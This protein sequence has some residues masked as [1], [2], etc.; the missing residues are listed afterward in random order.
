MIEDFRRH[1]EGR[2]INWIAYRS[3]VDRAHIH[4]ILNGQNATIY[5]LNRIANAMGK[6]IEIK[7]VDKKKNPAA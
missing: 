3:G 5:T 4:R 7:L 6:E 2:K 1:L